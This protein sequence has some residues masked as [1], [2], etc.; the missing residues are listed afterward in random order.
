MQKILVEK[1]NELT[2]LNERLNHKISK[3]SAVRE[4]L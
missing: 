3:I 1:D 4:E 2:K